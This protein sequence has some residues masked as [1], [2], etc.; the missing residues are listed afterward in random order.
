MVGRPSTTRGSGGPARSCAGRLRIAGL[1][2]ADA[3]EFYAYQYLAVARPAPMP[4]YGLTSIVILT[5]NQ[6]EYT[7]KCLESLRRLTDEPYELIV[8]DNGSTDGTMEYL[9]TLPGVRLIPN[10]TNRGFP[11]AANQ[12]IAAST[13]NQ[14]LLLNNDTIVTTGWLGRLLR[15]L[16]SDP[17]IGLVGPCSNCVS[18]PQQVEVRYESLADLD[19]F[20][21]DWGKAHDGLHGRRH[22]PGWVLLA[23][24]PG[25]HRSESGSWTSSSASA[26]TMT[27]ITA[28]AA[29]QAG[30]RAVIAADAFVHHFGG[31]TFIGM[32]MDFTAVMNQ[33]EQRF[34][35]KWSGGHRGEHFSPTTDRLK[36]ATSHFGAKAIRG[37][38]GSRGR[39]AAVVRESTALALHDRPGLG[40]N[41]PSLSGEHPALGQRDGHRG[42][43]IGRRDAA[44]RRVVRRPA[45]PFPLV[46]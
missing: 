33:N 40:P 7:R 13:G 25:G 38:H 21:W 29:I 14:I 16:H 24:P 3:D 2:D 4:D 32:G 37:Q 19:G 15:A 10:D 30:Y 27:T 43:R 36:P 42:Y 34:R 23:D 22:P 8:V 39:I 6:L 18:G 1:S 31:Q 9:G 41:A 35:D 5:H 12:G 45:V 26:A 11:A 46:R 44:D 28:C 17:A 20:A